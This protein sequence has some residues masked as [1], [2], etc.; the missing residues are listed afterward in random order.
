MDLKT[1][2]IAA[3]IVLGLPG[4]A[5]AAHLGLLAARLAVL[6]R[7]ARP[8]TRRDVALPRARPRARRGA[9]DRTA[10][11]GDHGRPARARPR[12]RRRRPLHRRDGARSPA[13]WA[14]RSSSAARTTRRAAPPPARPASSTRAR[15][16]W[17]AVLM[18]DADSVIEPGF[19]AS[20]E[21]ALG[22]G[23]PAVQ[24]R[25]ES[26]RAHARPGGVARRVHAAGHHDP[27]RP[28]PARRLGPAARDRDGDPARRRAGAPLPRAGLGGPLLHARPAARGH[29]LPPRRLRAPALAGRE[30]AG[31][32]S[33]AR[34]CATRRAGWRRRA[35]TSR[36]CCAARS[37]QRDAACLEATWFLATPPFAV[38]RAV[39]HRRHGA[40][41][42]RRR[43][44][45]WRRCSAPARAAS[46]WRWPPG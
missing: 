18:L 46:R 9:G 38:A 7:A 20:C 11:R 6:P 1:L 37:A 27:A 13:R 33:A 16:E 28:R 4:L 40:R 10:P 23:A 29:P 22:T 24:A 30:H 44:G 41:G 19:F 31:A 26:G 12:P 45:R 36:G 34:R 35:R 32:R 42:G 14:P 15:M 2:V 3:A 21:Q 25:S 8:R 17:D 43:A 5:V 39:G